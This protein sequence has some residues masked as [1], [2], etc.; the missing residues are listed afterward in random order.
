MASDRIPVLDC[1]CGTCE[2]NG[3]GTY[4]MRARCPNCGQ[5]VV[6]TISKGHERPTVGGPA[7]PSCGCL[8]WAGFELVR[9]AV[10]ADAD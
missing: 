5:R 2:A 6:M 4:Q 7:C 1:T 8:W 3:R 10:A 9:E